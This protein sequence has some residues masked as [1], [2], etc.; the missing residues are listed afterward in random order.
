MVWIPAPPRS[1]EYLIQAGL[2]MWNNFNLTDAIGTWGEQYYQV[3][4]QAINLRR[5]PNFESLQTIQLKNL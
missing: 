3:F 5:N 4:L 2:N 1:T